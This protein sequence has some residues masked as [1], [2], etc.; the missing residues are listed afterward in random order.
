MARSF[1]DPYGPLRMTLRLQG[2]MVGF[3]LGALLLTIPDR[4]MGMWGLVI[5]QT[6]WPARMAGAALVGMGINN[7]ALAG[8]ETMRLGPIAAAMTASGLL[9]GVFFFSYLQGDLNDL[10]RLGQIVL[11]TAFVLCLSTALLPIR[12]FRQDLIY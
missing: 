10:T 4:S 7:L 3:A 2:V 8:E 9:V 6:S 11:I 1:N 5:E 12:Y